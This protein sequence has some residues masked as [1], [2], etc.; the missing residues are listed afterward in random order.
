MRHHARGVPE[1]DFL[2]K[3]LLIFCRSLA[4]Q[5]L[6]I[7]REIA[8]YR[9][10]AFCGRLIIELREWEKKRSWL[11]ICYQV[12]AY[13]SDL[14]SLLVWKC[15]LPLMNTMYVP[16]NVIFSYISL[17]LKRTG[18]GSQ[19]NPRL[20]P[21]FLNGKPG[22]AKRILSRIQ[23][24]LISLFLIFQKMENDKNK[25][26]NNFKEFQCEWGEKGEKKEKNCSA[27]ASKNRHLGYARVPRV[28][29]H[30]SHTNANQL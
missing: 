3:I 26:N 12:H 5:A 19:T 17:F 2:V 29:T 20:P 4:S 9:S 30:G 15:G 24:H 16:W 7:S 22:M 6:R 8:V 25:I 18:F 13:T 14:P 28:A 23:D 10:P 1:F 11:Q 21:I 27:K